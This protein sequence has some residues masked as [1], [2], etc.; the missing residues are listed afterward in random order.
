MK[1]FLFIL[2]VVL[3][4]MLTIYSLLRTPSFQKFAARI[5]VEYVS[6]NYGIE[7]YLDKL[8]ISDM[9]S[10]ELEGLVVK[11]HHKNTLLN[12][13]DLRVQIREISLKEKYIW[14]SRVIVDRL[15]FML[16]QYKG[17]SLVNMDV[18]LHKLPRGPSDTTSTTSTPWTI[19]CDDLTLAGTSFGFTDDGVAHD[20]EI[21]DFT[22]ILIRDINLEAKDVAVIGD[23][24]AT[25]IQH[26]SF[27]EK[28]GLQVN[29]FKAIAS[30][31]SSGIRAENLQLK[32]NHT[33]ASMDVDFLYH[34]M[35]KLA[36]FLDSVIIDAR[37]RTSVLTLSDIGC[38]AP[39][40]K[41]MDD[42]IMFSGNVK[43]SITDFAAKDFKFSIGNLTEF[44]GDVAMK[45]LPDIY[46]TYW[47][48]N[49]REFMVTVEDFM[50]F[51]LPVPD[52]SIELPDQL[53]KMGLT[54]IKGTFKG[55]YNDF[56]ADLAVTS[57][58]GAVTVTGTMNTDARSGDPV[59]SGE[60]AAKSLSLKVLT[61][62]KELGLC[63]VDL[64]FEGKSLDPDKVDGNL[65]GWVENLDVLDHSYEKIVF[66][67][68]I[69]GKSFDGR[70]LVMDPG[71]QLAFNGKV[72]LNGETPEFDFTCDLETAKFYDLNLSDKSP[73][74]DLQGNFTARFAGLNIDKFSGDISIRRLIYHEK[75]EDYKIDSINLHRERIPGVKDYTQLQSD[76]VDATV[77]GPLLI[78]SL[79]FQL[80][81]LIFDP[82]SHPKS[83]EL[84]SDTAD[85][86]NFDI[87][88]KDLDPVSEVF[89]PTMS[90]SLGAN[91]HGRIDFSNNLI[92]FK[93]LADSVDV[94]GIRFDSVAL[95]CSSKGGRL[96]LQ[97]FV[98]EII[99]S[100]D[101]DSNALGI[102]NFR[103]GADAG[104]D[105]VNFA[106]A[107]DNH[108]P[109][110][111]NH[112]NI[113][114]YL[115]F[116]SA[117]RLEARLTEAHADL[118][119]R[120]WN[121]DGK[122]YIII[123]PEFKEI[124]N[125]NIRRDNETF[126]VNGRL[127]DQPEDTLS[128]YFKDWSL[129]SFN[130][131]LEGSSMSLDGVI[132][133]KFGIFKNDS[134]PNLFAGL[135]IKNFELNNVAFGDASINSRWMESQKA[136]AVEVDLYSNSASGEQYRILG[137]NGMY[138][139]FDDSKNFDFD[140]RTQNLDIS[141][142]EPML[143]SFSSK[144]AGFATGKLALKGTLAKPELTGS[145][146]L[147]RA[148]L[149]VDYLNVT[150]SFS[151]EITFDKDFIHF[152]K[153]PVI[154]AYNNEGIVTGGIRHDHFRNFTLDLNIQ[155][156]NLLAMD[157]NRYQNDVFYGT[158][159]ATGTIKLSGPFSRINIEVD[160]KTEKG[161]KVTIPINYSADVSQTNFIVFT[162]E[163][164]TA[165]VKEHHE[166]QVGG[167]SLHIGMNITKDADIEISLPGNIGY[168]KANGN[169]DLQ[170][171][172]DPNGYLNLTGSYKI[173]SGLFQFSLEQLVSRRFEI[174]EGSNITW[175]GDINDA[176]VNIV[177]RYRQRTSLNG[178]GSTLIS[179]EAA[180]QKVNVNTDIRM[181]GS[182]FNPD[183]SFGITFPNMQ[184]QDK[185]AVYAVLDTNDQALMN[186]QA[187]SLLV[188]NSFS[189]TGSGISN[190]VNP[191]T[192]MSNTLSSMLS[193]I[194]NDFNIGINYVPGDR[195][196]NEQLEVALS[197]QLLDDRLL[198]DGNI[199]YSPNNNTTQQSSAIVGDVNIEY[200]LTRDGRF[201]VKAFNRSNDLS[202]LNDY[203]P[204]TQGVGIFYRKD[205]S[206]LSE[207]FRGKGKK[208][209]AQNPQ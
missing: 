21:I 127:S 103:L 131:F 61:G 128:F 146:K 141:A 75:G 112:A 194:S 55:F 199:D 113:R 155:A 130:S 88:F 46:T 198:I 207:L 48:V 181:T 37:I 125:L 26:L 9:L 47:D 136:M 27:H 203:S 105:S 191:A 123:D 81:G 156:E 31:S 129:N 98:K 96:N 99:L 53:K 133:G 195:V 126:S 12:A 202:L 59:Y 28:S 30:V 158:A 84:V 15:D 161:T 124:R 108:N 172:V 142:L 137:V 67:G 11:D 93:A 168:I 40:L 192:I 190:P 145:M 2:V 185:Q 206:N 50:N 38:F 82:E 77:E 110:E 36:Y 170:L 118:N 138:Y 71:L 169:G 132:N 117:T 83:N 72:D 186:Q 189:T 85:H 140:I 157:L 154:D 42:P 159:F 179:D 45:G 204:Y 174:M 164:D 151:N 74:M 64:E 68:N 184:E 102:P 35:D 69:L 196:T 23:S 166:V 176:E 104:H 100:G 122:N 62:S 43:G 78:Q 57:D 95:L 148:E 109:L 178:L 20:G 52:N 7:V 188:L 91:V 94:S 167:V 56:K 163:M 29:D 18:M 107:W 173:Q 90:V 106:I 111:S 16:H 121:L 80:E 5:A 19:Y 177:A 143:S 115:N 54:G 14:L 25:R 152:D 92:D 60:V 13:K 101:A 165:Q 58:I 153:V 205:F 182:L 51:S 201:R 135:D 33:T 22:D 1:S 89:F 114:G 4:A 134:V 66:G 44:Q 41:K 10:I 209:K 76:I 139:P 70:V 160:A 187:I 73:D 86:L 171:G 6:K 208:K 200:K 162:N 150:Y 34:G 3:T 79:P 183:L 119:N 193:Q 8:R 39:E 144:V 65:N 24:I 197:T 120:E 32:T 116:P 180:N 17:D 147:L 49:F 87:V 97:G 149:K 63:D 175:T